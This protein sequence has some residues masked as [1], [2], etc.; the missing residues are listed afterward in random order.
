MPMYIDRQKAI[1][2]LYGITAYKNTIPLS[3]AIF[4]IEKIPTADVV[5]R[6][7]IEAELDLAYKHGWSDCFAEHRWIPV[8]ERLPERKSFDLVTDFG[9]VEEAYYDSDGNWWQVWGDKLKNVT[10]WMPLPEPY[11][12][13]ATDA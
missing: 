1:D 3:S 6:K 10:A 8:S 12:E 13:E 9:E 11:R 2:A 5:E 7:D 4:N